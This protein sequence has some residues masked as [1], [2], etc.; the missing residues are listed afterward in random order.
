LDVDTFVDYFNYAT[1]TGKR[2]AGAGQYYYASPSNN[3]DIAYRDA[4]KS[5]K[6]HV[7]LVNRS[8]TAKNAGATGEVKL[9]FVVRPIYGV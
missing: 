2:I 7:L 3:L 8:A 1:T 6:L 4:D 5:G 9:R